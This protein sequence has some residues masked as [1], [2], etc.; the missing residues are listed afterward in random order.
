LTVPLWAAAH[1]FSVRGNPAALEHY[2][3]E[4]RA[5]RERALEA[6]RHR[7]DFAESYRLAVELAALDYLL[8]RSAKEQVAS[9]DRALA[10]L[11]LDAAQQRS[12]DGARAQIFEGWNRATDRTPDTR[13]TPSE[14]VHNAGR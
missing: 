6:A 9:F 14:L 1:R 4:Q 10:G 13:P 5:P 2:V 7:L 8:G 3:A 11:V 12:L